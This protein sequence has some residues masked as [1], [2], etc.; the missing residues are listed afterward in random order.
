MSARDIQI[1]L[2]GVTELATDFAGR[3]KNFFIE[4][5]GTSHHSVPFGGRETDLAQLDA[6]LEHGPTPYLLL[7]APAGRGKSALLAHWSQRLL[8]RDNLAIAFVPVSIRFSTN[9]AG[10]FFVA[11]TARL[12]ALH[13]EKVPANLDTS[14]EAWRGLMSDYLSR[15]L[16]D[17]RRLLLIIDGLD[18]AGWQVGAD[19]FPFAPPEGLRIII[20]TRYIAGDVDAEGWMRRLGWNRTDLAGSL[21]LDPLTAEGVADVLRL[22][23]FPLNRLGAQEDI[24][25][26]LYCL[27]EGD[28]LLV[29]LYVDDLRSRGDRVAHLRPEDLRT[30]EPGLKG[31]FDRW[32]EEQRRLWGNQAP[33]RE[34]AVQALLDVLSCALGP[35]S[36]E[37]VL[38]LVPKESRLNSW[39]LEEAWHPLERFV[40]G[41]G[42]QQK[43][44]FGHPR[45]GVY[46]YER[47]SEWERQTVESRFLDV[48]REVCGALNEGKLLP[49]RASSYFVQYYGAHLE[50]AG[51]STEALLSL[52][53]DGWRQAWVALEGS[54]TGFL[55]DIGKAWSAV[56]RDDEE[57]IAGRGV[58]PYLG[59]E[60]RCALCQ[61][62]INSLAKNIPPPLLT[63]LVKH[64]IWTPV[65]GLAY[66]RQVP[67]SK[68]RV[69][70]LAALIPSLLETKSLLERIL[71]TAL[72]I[73]D[74]KDRVQLLIELAPYL[75]KNQ[76]DEV[77]WEA[78]HSTQMIE[79]EGSQAL[80]LEALIP[81]LSGSL[82][83]KALDITLVMNNEI[84]QTK[85]LA[86]LIR[87]LPEGR[88][89]EALHLALASAQQLNSFVDLTEVMPAL[90]PY[91]PEQQK[92]DLV[93][94]MLRQALD[95]AL[96]FR[97]D[98]LSKI[99]PF[100]SEKQ[101]DVVVQEAFKL[102][103]KLRLEL[104]R[105]LALA[106]LAPYLSRS[107]LQNGLKKALAIKD[108]KYRAQALVGLAPYLAEQ[109]KSKTMLEMLKAAHE[110]EYEADGAEALV[111]L[112]PHLPETLKSEVVQEA[113][114]MAWTI[115]DHDDR[116]IVLATLIPY[117][118]ESQKSTVVQKTLETTQT[119]SESFRALVLGALAPY[120]S[121]HLLQ[122]ALKA[123]R[124]ITSHIFRLEALGVLAPYLPK[125]LLQEALKIALAIKD[126]EYRVGE[127]AKL[128]TGLPE[129][130]KNEVVGRALEVAQ[131]VADEEL[132]ARSLVSLLPELSEPL[133]REAL[134]T[135]RMMNDKRRQAWTL[136]KLSSYL[137]DP[138][139]NEVV[140]EALEGTQVVK[141]GRWDEDWQVWTLSALAPHLPT[142]LLQEAWKIALKM[143]HKEYRAKMLAMLV[144]HFPQE[145]RDEVVQKALEAIRMLQD[146]YQPQLLTKLVPYLLPELKDEVV[147]G[148][149]FMTQYIKD[150]AER[151]E[152]LAKL[153]P[154]LSSLPERSFQEWLLYFW[155]RE[156]HNESLIEMLSVLAPYFSQSSLD[157]V[158]SFVRNIEDAVIQLCAL[159]VLASYLPEQQKGEVV[160]KVLKDVE[161]VDISDRAKVQAYLAPYLPEPLL[162]ESLENTQSSPDQ[163]KVLA[164]LAPYLS[165]QQLQNALL[166]TQRSRYGI[167]RANQLALLTPRLTELFPATLYSLWRHRLHFSA[168]YSREELVEELSALAPI[169]S[170]L[171]GSKA[172]VETCHTI[173]EMG[174]WWP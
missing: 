14:P 150:D 165:D 45:L 68:Q 130:Q 105:A 43:F 102:T 137:T 173:L 74:N 37:D 120:L 13:N 122:E 69:A 158:L 8:A 63:A 39:M 132:R 133:L 20:S 58:A 142:V 17:G 143:E 28:P 42:K 117:L 72:V 50:R 101:R 47:L 23:R 10:V 124:T 56:E 76:K 85:V 60:I 4:Y 79:Y 125:P 168:Q 11:L 31:Y 78:L 140:Q 5:L 1:I 100:L 162:Q 70:A 119:T 126:E 30:I 62:S 113:L 77:L 151:I 166:I 80:A 104:S 87:Y 81:H 148:A 139:K 138:L 91:L 167:D 26:E 114:K 144:P 48:G 25:T 49:K 54:H 3:I 93:Q 35:L 146:K 7:A 82:L 24:V 107:L 34:T 108:P 128:V 98:A 95:S 55:N 156:S 19:L 16:P 15:P 33:L 44:V 12:A 9:L 134:K 115:E 164:K 135:F 163:L 116:A 141:K 149:L 109:S 160:Q 88:R 41:D 170:K 161:T 40:L 67:D 18:E 36:T 52:V 96:E 32:W 106:D 111:D 153:G 94:R 121:E 110:M 53:S 123:V 73:D 71:E 172:L 21:V 155:G 157:W 145:L 112:T 90:A 57:A 46:F 83:L 59:S 92:D 22:M 6:W 38:R 127:L 27:S 89:D 169:V 159:T 103:S 174:Q 65:Q 75:S 66:A 129:E 99:L 61:T 84:S 29:R 147:Q 154:N 64:G 152:V 118:P 97:I 171:G 86:K 131:M 51:Q 136:A 2:A